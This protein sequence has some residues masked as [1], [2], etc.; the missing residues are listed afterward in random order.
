MVLRSTVS[1]PPLKRYMPPPEPPVPEAVLPEIV[2][3]MTLSTATE[4][5]PPDWTLMPPPS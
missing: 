5:A 4:L 3:L 1:L 2:E